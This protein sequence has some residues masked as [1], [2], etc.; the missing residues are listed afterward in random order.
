MSDDS[1][2]RTLKRGSFA[3]YGLSAEPIICF[4]RFGVQHGLCGWKF[5]DSIFIWGYVDDGYNAFQTTMIP[6]NPANVSVDI[7]EDMRSPTP[8]KHVAVPVIASRGGA[9]QASDLLQIPHRFHIGSGFA[10]LADV[11]GQAGSQVRIDST[12]SLS[13]DERLLSRRMSSRPHPDRV[14]LLALS[15]G[16][17]HGQTSSPTS[18]RSANLEPCSMPSRGMKKPILT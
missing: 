17:F 9:E 3:T 1:S 12:E 5:R 16:V 15:T 10:D 8:V 14:P 11:D 6:W 18:A 7:A 2:D 4:A 13:S